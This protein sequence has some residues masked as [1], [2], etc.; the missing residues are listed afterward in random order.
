MKT[1]L[2]ITFISLLTIYVIWFIYMVLKPEPLFSLCEKCQIN[3]GRIIGWE[4]HSDLPFY[5]CYLCTPDKPPKKKGL[6]IEEQKQ[7][8]LHMK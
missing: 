2:I 7:L 5:E 4:A 1:L 3:E 6:T 8:I